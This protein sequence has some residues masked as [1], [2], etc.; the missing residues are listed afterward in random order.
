MRLNLKTT[1][2]SRE[3]QEKKKQWGSRYSTEDDKVV[4]SESVD[5]PDRMMIVFRDNPF[6]R[7]LCLTPKE[8][9]KHVGY[10]IG[11]PVTIERTKLDPFEYQFV[12]DRVTQIALC[13]Q[14]R[15]LPL[16]PPYLTLGRLSR[17]DHVQISKIIGKILF[18]PLIGDNL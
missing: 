2:T 10:W 4:L 18:D 17:T 5:V 7:W 6:N 15:S 12:L 8:W 9:N 3:K 14:P 1:P 11:L 13:S 16:N